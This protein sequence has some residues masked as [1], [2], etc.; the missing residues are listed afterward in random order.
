MWEKQREQS[1]KR[2]GSRTV[3]GL[4][5]DHQGGLCSWSREGWVWGRG[6]GGERG[7][8]WW[9]TG[10]DLEKTLWAMERT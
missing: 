2:P 1:V 4:F 3:P 7:R 10:L 6:G 9:Q 8:R 5:K